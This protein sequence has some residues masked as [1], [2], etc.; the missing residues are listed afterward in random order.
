M[1]ELR[2]RI[3][4][5]IGRPRCCS[6]CARNYPPPNGRWEGGYCCGTDTWRVFTDD[7]LQALAAAGTDTATMSSPRSDHAGCTFRGPTG[8]SIAPWDRPNICARY[9]CLTLVAE[10]RERGDLKP[11][12]AMCNALA[13]EFTRFLELRAARVNRDELQ[14]L[15]RELASAAPGRRGTGTP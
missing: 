7:E 14:E 8:C 5:A 11:I 13:K 12:D 4:E 15:E 1:R 10:L 2:A 3:S 9:L 6:E